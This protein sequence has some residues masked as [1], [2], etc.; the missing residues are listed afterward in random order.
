[1]A[2]STDVESYIDGAPAAVQPAMRELRKLIF[3]AAPSA[4]ERISYGMPA[5]D[6]GGR[7]LLHFS[8]AKR[9]LCIYGLVH[10]DGSTPEQLAEY[11]GH[12]STLRFRL[13]RPLPCHQAL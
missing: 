12:R 8:A 2:Q 10:V 9:H 7:H 3:E 4:T 13:D 5:Y 11:H 6:H 1:M